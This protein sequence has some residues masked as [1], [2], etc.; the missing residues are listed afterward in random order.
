M[1]NFLGDFRGPRPARVSE[2]MRV[3]S[4]A[5]RRLSRPRWKRPPACLAYPGREPSAAA[6]ITTLG[7]QRDLRPP[8]AWVGRY[9]RLEQSG[10]FLHLPMATW[11]GSWLRRG[12]HGPAGRQISSG[13]TECDTETVAVDECR[14]WPPSAGE[15]RLNGPAAWTSARPATVSTQESGR[16]GRTRT[17]V[18]PV[19]SGVR[20]LADR[21]GLRPMGLPRPAR[22]DGCGLWT[23]TG[24]NGR[25]HHPRSCCCQVHSY[26][27]DVGVCVCVC[28]AV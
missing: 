17:R 25:I 3:A 24:G 26:G 11:C 23:T 21:E 10:N 9:G 7:N 18:E 20:D 8:P 16:G 27:K 14:G 13:L 2:W 6:S 1:G 19:S 22:R 4:L 28:A 12:L 5:L 15:K